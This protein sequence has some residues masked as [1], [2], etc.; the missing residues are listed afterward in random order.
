VR[1][2]SV[3]QSAPVVSEVPPVVI[4]AVPSGKKAQLLVRF[5]QISDLFPL[6]WGVN[7]G[8]TIELELKGCDEQVSPEDFSLRVDDAREGSLKG[9]GST[10]LSSWVF[11]VKGVHRLKG[12]FSG[13]D[14]WEEVTSEVEVKIVDYREEIVDLFN[15]FFKSAKTKFQSV[16]DEM[17]P[18]ELQNALVGQIE[19]SKQ[20]PLETAVSVFEVADYSLHQVARRDYERIYLALK[21]LEG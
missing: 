15:S 6:V 20:E 2:S 17:T 7:E 14:G 4:A 1:S 21:K 10:F 3:E 18:R 8:L 19:A 13:K 16:Q 12:K 5:P 9:S 11:D